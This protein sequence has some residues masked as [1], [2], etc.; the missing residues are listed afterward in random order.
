MVV[1]DKPTQLVSLSIGFHHY[2]VI[3]A[4]KKNVLN[5]GHL[6]NRGGGSA[7][8]GR[9]TQPPYLVIRNVKTMGLFLKVT[10]LIWASE[11]QNNESKSYKG[12]NLLG[13]A[14]DPSLEFNFF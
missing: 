6:P 5:L 1:I 12:P 2:Y 7:R 14:N 4:L 10:P 11:G 13:L 9:L 8:I 3:E